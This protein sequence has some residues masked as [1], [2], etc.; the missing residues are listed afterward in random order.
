MSHHC[1][2]KGCKRPA[3]KAQH[4]LCAE[5][6]PEPCPVCFDEIVN[7][8]ERMQPPKGLPRCCQ[9]DE[10]SVTGRCRKCGLAVRD[11]ASRVASLDVEPLLRDVRANM[12]WSYVF[13]GAYEAMPHERIIVA[14]VLRWAADQVDEIRRAGS[15]EAINGREVVG[16]LR[17]AA[18]AA[19][20]NEKYHRKTL[21]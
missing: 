3:L 6:K 5:H 11:P 18:K 17:S 16:I 4:H 2:I 19:G 15:G 13:S 14:L 1:A 12:P 9:C 7:R 21:K 10:P 8:T 20:Q